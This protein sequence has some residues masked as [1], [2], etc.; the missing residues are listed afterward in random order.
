[1]RYEKAQKE[2]SDD[3]IKDELCQGQRPLLTLAPSSSLSGKALSPDDVDHGI[4]AGCYSAILIA[5]SN[6]RDDYFVNDARRGHI[7]HVT[8]EPVPDFESQ[9]SIRGHDEQ[10]QSI[11][12]S[13]PSNLPLL[14]RPDRPVFDR[15]ISS[16]CAD[17]D[18]ELV[19]CP[20]RVL[21]QTRVK[22]TY[23]SWRHE[24]CRIGYP[25]AGRGRDR[26]FGCIQ[27]CSRNE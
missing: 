16:S 27:C 6:P 18:D 7:R 25:T 2:D 24:V 26:R 12:N 3:C 15:R 22:R 23:S 21:I 11:V 20:T 1:M 13:L 10:S 14:E 17:V 19:T 8:F 9:L 5:C 4:H